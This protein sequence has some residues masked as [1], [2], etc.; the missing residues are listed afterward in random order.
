[1]FPCV[2]DIR[3]YVSLGAC[4]Q[5]ICFL[6]CMSSGY[7]FHWVHEIRLYVSLGV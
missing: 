2:Y 1:M 3:L 4:D 7:M 6:V 5:V